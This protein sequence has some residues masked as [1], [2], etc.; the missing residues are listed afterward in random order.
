MAPSVGGAPLEGLKLSIQGQEKPPQ[1]GGACIPVFLVTPDPTFGFLVYLWFIYD[2]SIQDGLS[3]G[4]LL[5]LL[6]HLL[7]H[8]GRDLVK[9][10]AAKL[11]LL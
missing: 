6:Y 1:K 9:V 5:H 3:Y 10:L 7:H 11:H 4:W 2:C 8:G